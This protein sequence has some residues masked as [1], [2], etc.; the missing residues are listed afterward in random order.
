MKKE[1]LEEDNYNMKQEIFDKMERL[2]KEPKQEACDNCNNDVCCCTIKKQETIEDAAEKFANSKKWMNEGVDNWVQHTFKKGAEWQKEQ[3]KKMYSE[4][5]VENIIQ[6]LM[7][8]VH[9]G[10]LCYGEYVIDFKLSPR[11]WFEQF[12]KK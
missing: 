4:E 6:K 11:Q 3:D 7:H 2:E 1:T 12:K 9:C 5:E 8:D 10:D